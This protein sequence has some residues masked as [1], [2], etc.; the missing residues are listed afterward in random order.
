MITVRKISVSFL[1]AAIILLLSGCGSSFSLQ[2]ETLE[3]TYPH[4]SEL[5]G[6]GISGNSVSPDRISSDSLSSAAISDSTMSSDEA[7][8]SERDYDVGRDKAETYGDTVSEADISDMKAGE[9]RVSGTH[10][11]DSSGNIVML[12]GVSTHGLE[13]YPEY[14]NQ[15]AFH[16]LKTEWNVNLIRLA[17]YT[18]GDDGY[19]SLPDNKRADL[20]N[21][22]DNAV[23][24]ATNE[25]MYVIIDWH[26][27][28]SG[29]PDLYADDAAEY[30]SYLAEKYQNN[31][32]VIYEICNEPNGNTT[33]SD[34][35]SYA[36]RIIPVI[37]AKSDAIVIV[38]TP[39]WSQDV[40][41]AAEDPL[42][43][44]NVV[45]ALHFYAAS[46]NKSLQLKLKA[47]EDKGLPVFVSEFGICDAAGDGKIDKESAD[48]WMK[49]LEKYGTGSCIWNLSN[50]DEASALIKSSCSSTSG[51]TYDELSEEGQWYY[52]RK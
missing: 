32:N 4:R 34:I 27:L 40:D 33:W 51:W 39:G 43:Y 24:Y 22:V 49:L 13:W 37:R 41:T 5:S 9:L 1:A 11:I 20:R 3:E 42:D 29:D 52:D 21:L 45:Y 26:V 44:D 12:R 50:K 2:G 47:A 46:H 35:K 17:L 30:F 15:E 14:V 18:D 16:T 7:E 28:Q 23:S 8:S 19:C 6:D 48:T 38:G 36:S 10:I 31:T 25:N